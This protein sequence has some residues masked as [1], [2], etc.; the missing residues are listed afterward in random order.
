MLTLSCL[1]WRQDHHTAREVFLQEV[2]DVNDVQT[3]LRPATVCEPSQL[4]DHPGDSVFVCDYMY[5]AGCAVSQHPGSLHLH[6]PAFLGFRH[7]SECS[8]LQLLLMAV[9]ALT[10]LC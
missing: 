8:P 5:H 10:I 2:T 3:L 6:F 9:A 4:Q 7:F 1:F